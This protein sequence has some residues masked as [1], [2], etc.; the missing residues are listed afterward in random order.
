RS[1][2][3]ACSAA[4]GPS[5]ACPNPGS[6]MCALPATS[7]LGTAGEGP[8]GAQTATPASRSRSPMAPRHR[9]RGRRRSCR[10]PRGPPRVAEWGSG[11]VTVMIRQLPRQYTQLMFL[12]E[13]N[14]RGFEGL[15]DFV[16][17][18]FDSKKDCNVGYGFVNF[19]EVEHAE[20]FRNE[21]DG[22]YLA[23]SLRNH[24]KPLRIHPAAMQGY[25]AN[26][27]HFEKSKA[28]NSQDGGPPGRGCAGLG[29]APQA[30]PWCGQARGR[31]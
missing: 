10:P 14:S 20:R 29:L 16:Y 3:R 15:F 8:S 18:P 31:G 7:K 4:R 2:R 27:H 22:M 5:R 28:S 17:F 24:G 23:H 12:E 25:E 6:A 11:V 13:L 26:Y 9:R 1:S 19:T 30:A 21:F